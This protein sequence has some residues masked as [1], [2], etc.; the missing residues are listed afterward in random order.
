MKHLIEKN[1]MKVGARP[2]QEY[3]HPYRMSFEFLEEYHLLLLFFVFTVILKKNYFCSV[4]KDS[5]L[6]FNFRLDIV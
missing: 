3:H 4:C 2:R 5:K 6:R 1:K